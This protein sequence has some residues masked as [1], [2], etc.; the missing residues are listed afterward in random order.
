VKRE[1]PLLLG[2]SESRKDGVALGVT[3]AKSPTR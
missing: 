3:G 2:A 1:G